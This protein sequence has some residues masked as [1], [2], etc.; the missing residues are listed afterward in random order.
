MS[1]STFNTRK[2]HRRDTPSSSKPRDIPGFYYDPE[3]K[4]YFKIMSNC[5]VPN[6]HPFSK[7][8][9]RQRKKQ[10]IQKKSEIAY[11]PSLQ[12]ILYQRE[13]MIQS[14]PS[15]ILSSLKLYPKKINMIPENQHSIQCMKLF[16][17]SSQCIIGDVKGHI[18]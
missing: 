13:F 12:R 2:R 4:K 14:N 9:I 3:R 6:T 11:H 10:T 1:Q 7:D 18:K 5:S 17:T 15:D 8:N 16:N